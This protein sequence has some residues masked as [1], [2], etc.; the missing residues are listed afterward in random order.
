MNIFKEFFLPRFS[1]EE[2]KK[3]N[4]RVEPVG[5][6]Y[7]I[8]PLVFN[9]NFKVGDEIYFLGHDGVG[10]FWYGNIITAN[11]ELVR[12]KDNLQ[13]YKLIGRLKGY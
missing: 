7:K 8:T 1:Q 12:K 10:G 13:F 2:C 11:E 6:L 5:C 4:L 9:K 3:F